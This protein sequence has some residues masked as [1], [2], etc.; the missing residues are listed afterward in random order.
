MSDSP[1]LATAGG[2]R[3]AARERVCD[4]L[5]GAILR[6]E[7]EPGV[8]LEEEAVGRA[9][10]V[11]RTPV[12]EAFHKLEAERYLDLH[13]RRGARVRQVTARE[14]LE[15]YETRR[16][17]EGFAATKLCQEGHPLPAELRELTRA[18]RALGDRDL[19]RH[20]ELD[21]LLHRSL[22]AAGRNAVLLE[23]YDRLRARQEC[24]AMTALNADPSRLPTILD[25]HEAIVAG[26]AARDHA[27]VV[28]ILGRHLQ[29]IGHVIAKLP[30]GVMP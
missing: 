18:M 21:R 9:T 2:Q 22:V 25:E 28:A 30:G 19:A 12:R 20:V 23:A 16:L 1:D 5:R 26:L 13:P 14:M 10:G 27:A 11:S 3:P 6:G 7:L 24:V 15:L 29:P 8:F 4:Y 17:I